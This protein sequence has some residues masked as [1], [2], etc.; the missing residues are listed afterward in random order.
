MWEGE[1]NEAFS[2][3]NYVTI[4]Y[5]GCV[6]PLSSVGRE[7]ARQVTMARSESREPPL[8]QVR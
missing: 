7:G 5:R 3:R 8:S 1:A 2:N 6:V 4:T